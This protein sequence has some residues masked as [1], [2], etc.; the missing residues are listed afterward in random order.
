MALL[1]RDSALARVEGNHQWKPTGG[2]GSDSSR[3]G[4]ARKHAGLRMRCIFSRRSEGVA[5][6]VAVT[7]TAVHL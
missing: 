3:K 2:T 4:N 1:I 5:I 6:S 7:V